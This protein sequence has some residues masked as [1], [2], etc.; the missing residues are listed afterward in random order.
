MLR[1]SCVT[2]I[3]ARDSSFGDLGVHLRKAAGT[4]I[5]AGKMRHGGAFFRND[6]HR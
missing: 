5:F 2:A 1:S 6:G 3:G 4:Q